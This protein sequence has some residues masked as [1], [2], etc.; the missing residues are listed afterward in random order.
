MNDINIED[1]QLLAAA[2]QIVWTEH[3]ALRMRERNIKRTDVINCIQSGE[4]I[5]Q[6]PNA[7]PN[8]AC[9]LFAMIADNKPLHVVAGIGDGKLFIIT[10]YIPTLDKWES[11]L[12]TRKAGK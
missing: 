1:L 11:D 5:E 2:K 6:Y 7:Y 3:L 4:I 10:A 8:P 9:L 12:K